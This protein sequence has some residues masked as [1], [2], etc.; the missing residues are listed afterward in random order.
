MTTIES[1]IRELRI[2]WGYDTIELNHIREL[3]EEYGA[4]EYTRGILQSDK[5]L[6]YEQSEQ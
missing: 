4:I 2:T 1:I 5:F 3:L 6:K